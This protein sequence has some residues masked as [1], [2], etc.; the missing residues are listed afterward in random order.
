MVRFL[1]DALTPKQARIAALLKLEG[2]KRGVEVEITCRHY[3]HVSDI[4]DMYGVSYR[5]FGQYGLTVYE[6]LVYGIER[7]RELAEVARQVD[8]MLGFPSPDAARVVFGLGKPVLVLNDTP[9]ATHVN[10]LVIPLSEAL[11]APAAIPEEMWRPYCPRKVVTFDGVFEYMWTSRFKPDESVVKSLGLEPG[12]YVVFRPEERY[13]AYY[14]WEYTEL[15]IKLA[16]AV[17]GL[18][19][20]VVN[21]P[22]YP[23][24][25]LE[26]AINLTRAVDHLQLAYFS[27]GVITG[28]ASMATEA[29]L[30]GVPALSYFPQSYYVDRY[31]AEKGAPLY[32][33]DS[34]ETCLSSLREMLR[35]GRS[36]PVRLED[37][38]GIIFDAAL[39]A[40][41]R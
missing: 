36:A 38:A 34:L 20:N 30:L 21:V 28:G 13:A 10:R 14:K 16:R 19:Y 32:R 17:E 4:L 35:R 5:C 7:Q 29:A 15:R 24:Q 12:G 23:D 2:A 8:G 25:V 39:S 26:G 3:M 1:S 37:P 22:R 18:G 9:H 27:A 41:S 40:V 31:L 33:C 6:K 11:V